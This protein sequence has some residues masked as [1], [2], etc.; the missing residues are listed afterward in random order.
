MVSPYWTLLFSRK[1]V[2]KFTEVALVYVHCICLIGCIVIAQ[3]YRPCNTV[4]TTADVCL[5]VENDI[6]NTDA[7]YKVC[8]NFFYQPFGCPKAN[9]GWLTRRQSHTSMLITTLFQVLLCLIVGRSNKQGRWVFRK[10]ILK[11]GDHNK[12]TLREYWDY[13]IK[14]DD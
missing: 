12:M 8:G 6:K 3:G 7:K 14:W 10:N 4:N 5:L 11:L 2:I 1:E 9:F 13:T